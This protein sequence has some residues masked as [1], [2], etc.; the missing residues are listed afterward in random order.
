M[1]VYR[2]QGSIFGSVYAVLWLDGRGHKHVVR[3]FQRLDLATAHA[4]ELDDLSWRANRLGPE[5][6]FAQVLDFAS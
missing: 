1:R 2:V 4:R 3:Y 6:E 5:P